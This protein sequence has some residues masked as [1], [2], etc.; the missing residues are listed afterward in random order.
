VDKQIPSF[1]RM[2]AD[3]KAEN[4]LRL[5]L[6]ELELSESSASKA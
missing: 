3:R 1:N 5:Y 2:T 6:E 4:G